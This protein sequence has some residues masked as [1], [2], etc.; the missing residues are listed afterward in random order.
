MNGIFIGVVFGMASMLALTLTHTKSATQSTGIDIDIDVDEIVSEAT[1]HLHL[2]EEH[3]RNSFTEEFE[4]IDQREVVLSRQMREHAMGFWIDGQAGYDATTRLKVMI[5]PSRLSAVL[6]ALLPFFHAGP[7]TT[8]TNLALVSGILLEVVVDS[9]GDAENTAAYTIQCLIVMWLGI[10]AL[11]Y[12]IYSFVASRSI[13]SC[14]AATHYQIGAD[15]MFEGVVSPII[16]MMLVLSSFS[17]HTYSDQD[18][19]C[20]MKHYLYPILLLC[21][22]KSLW[23]SLVALG[24]S[25]ASAAHVLLLFLCIL[26]FYSVI[27][28]LL[29]QDLY[30]TGD[31]YTDNQ[32]A[33]FFTAFTTMF[34]YLANGTQL[35]PTEDSDLKLF[36]Q[37]RIM[38]KLSHLHWE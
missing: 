24:H 23:R 10:D 3:I 1:P 19:H 22:N 13:L 35:L 17:S 6:T 25:A 14:G 18:W 4:S 32:Y 27:S 31:F 16:W 37:V 7:S 36:L 8:I 20:Q 21:R 30:Q 15:E 38:S 28:M 9:L 5:L 2:L 26:V 11:I 34:I 29:M 12:S 33:N